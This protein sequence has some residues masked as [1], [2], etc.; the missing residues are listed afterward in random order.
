MRQTT[1][2]RDA[3]EF[4]LDTTDKHAARTRHE[5]RVHAIVS[6]RRRRDL[7]SDARMVAGDDEMLRF[8]QHDTI[9]WTM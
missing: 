9:A 2:E 3:T 6:S 7:G 5:Y 8:A 1:M 4:D